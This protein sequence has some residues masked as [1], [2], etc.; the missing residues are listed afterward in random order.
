MTLALSKATSLTQ[1]MSLFYQVLKIMAW[2]FY[3]TTRES[4]LVRS[5]IQLT[6]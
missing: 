5:E 6:T 3:L 1:Q 2:I 4:N